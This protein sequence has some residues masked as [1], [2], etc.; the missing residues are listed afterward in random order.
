[1]VPLAIEDI[2][3]KWTHIFDS[4]DPH[5]QSEVELE[6]YPLLDNK[7]KEILVFNEEEFPIP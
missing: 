5:H 1:M 4:S 7:G 2:T 3:E 6:V